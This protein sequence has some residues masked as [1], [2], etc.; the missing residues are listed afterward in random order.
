MTPPGPAPDAPPNPAVAGQT[1][2]RD[3][4]FVRDGGAPPP[5][6]IPGRTLVIALT[7]ILVTVF[8]VNLGFALHNRSNAERMERAEALV[9]DPARVR[10]TWPSEP[11][12]SSRRP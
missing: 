10:A 2:D 6:Y 8:A 5:G 9:D 7:A 12:G 3:P 11:T 4:A 1:L